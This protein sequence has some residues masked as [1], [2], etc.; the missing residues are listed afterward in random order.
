M[1]AVMQYMIL[2][3]HTGVWNPN[4]KMRVKSYANH[5]ESESYCNS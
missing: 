5:S 2:G 3:K 4:V 1:P